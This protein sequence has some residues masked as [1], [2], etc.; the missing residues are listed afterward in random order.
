MRSPKGTT[1]KAAQISHVD[2]T[3]GKN[4][5]KK[6]GELVFLKRGYGEG[7]CFQMSG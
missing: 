1:D 2:F 7:K 5:N 4:D 3:I 6:V